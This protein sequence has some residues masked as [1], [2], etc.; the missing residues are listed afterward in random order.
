MHLHDLTIIHRMQGRLEISNIHSVAERR[1]SSVT[2]QDAHKISCQS[3]GSFTVVNRVDGHCTDE[4]VRSFVRMHGKEEINILHVSN[5]DVSVR[6]AT[7]T[8]LY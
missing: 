1:E 8:A 2:V 7:D 3:D 6:M 5:G 4:C